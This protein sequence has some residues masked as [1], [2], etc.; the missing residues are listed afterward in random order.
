[1][2]L[3]TKFLRN[4]LP[5]SIIGILITA[6]IS[7]TFLLNFHLNIVN[8]TKESILNQE[9]ESIKSTSDSLSL[10]LQEYFILKLTYL[11]EAIS[12]SETLSKHKILGPENV[13]ALNAYDLVVGNIDFSELKGFTAYNSSINLDYS[14]WFLNKS[15]TNVSLLSPKTLDRLLL[16]SQLEVEMKSIYTVAFGLSTIYMLFFD[17]GL[18]FIYPASKRV[19]YENFTSDNYC[20][21]SDYPSD[22]YDLRCASEIQFGREFLKNAPVNTTI[23]ISKAFILMEYGIFGVT[24]CAGHF[25]NSTVKNFTEIPQSERVLEYVICG[26]IVLNEING[27]FKKLITA[28]GGFYYV[29]DRFD[30]LAYHPAFE[31]QNFSFTDKIGSITEYEFDVPDGANDSLAVEFNRTILSL[32]QATFTNTGGM[33]N[34]QNQIIKLTYKKKSGDYIGTLSPIFFPITSNK[35]KYHG[36]NLIFIEQSDVLMQVKRK[37]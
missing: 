37:K 19:R 23:F 26:E 6:I 24:L 14:M 8:E 34:F 17:D 21:F 3:R 20:E 11:E 31:M 12:Y 35:E 27:I 2:S 32:S 22:Y 5:P 16:A 1:M 18:Q 25:K 30:N 15:V 29:L 7:I 33:L 36:A 10:S 9:Y 4:I 13:T 28:H